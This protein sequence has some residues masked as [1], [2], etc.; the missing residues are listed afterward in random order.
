[1]DSRDTMLRTMHDL[2]AAAWFGGSLMGAIGLN[3]AASDAKNPRE[4]ARLSAD[5]WMRWAPVNAAAVG[6]HLVGGAGL[7]WANKSRHG[8]QAGV[9]AN[10]AVKTVLTVS[11]LAASA[12]GAM[13]GARVARMSDGTVVEGATEPDETTPDGVASAQRQLK[14]LQW[15]TPALTATIIA[16]GSQQG[17]MQRPRAQVMQLVDRLAS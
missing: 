16:L 7:V 4:R 3:G 2:G 11:A 15:A 9:A 5:G 10:T 8:T 14:I 6:A 1:M 12:Y 17:E 13:L